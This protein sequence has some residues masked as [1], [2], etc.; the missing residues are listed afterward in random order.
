MCCTHKTKTYC[1]LTLTATL[2]PWLQVCEYAMKVTNGDV[3]ADEVPIS[4]RQQ[5]LQTWVLAKQM[6]QAQISKSYGTEDEVLHDTCTVKL[7]HKDH[8]DQQN[9][10]LIHKWSL[11][12]K[13]NN[14][15]SIPLGTC[16]MWS[17]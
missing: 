1:V 12:G 16:K 6:S 7:V 11:Y 9:M 8:M 2:L 4:V 17:L 3:P 14:M 15:E 5:L 10:L 13:C